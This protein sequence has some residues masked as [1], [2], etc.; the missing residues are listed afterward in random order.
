MKKK[1]YV[2]KN[3]Y[4]IIK[5]ILIEAVKIAKFKRILKTRA[6]TITKE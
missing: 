2:K 3:N 6:Y 1:S 4:M 5:S